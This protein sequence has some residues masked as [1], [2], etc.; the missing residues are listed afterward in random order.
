MISQFFSFRRRVVAVTPLVCVLVFLFLG[1]QFDLWH[2]GWLVF[3][4]VPIMPI[5]VG[6]KKIKWSFSF[7]ISIIYLILGLGFG[8]WHP[9][10]LIFL[11]IPIYYTLFPSGRFKKNDK[12]LKD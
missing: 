12:T 7:I 6:I 2:P 5:L 8:Y 11:L 1:F 10:W 9:G 4:L 3:L